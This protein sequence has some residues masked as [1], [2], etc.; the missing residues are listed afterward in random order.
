MKKLVVMM[1]LLLCNI[2]YAQC[3]TITSAEVRPLNSSYALGTKPQFNFFEVFSDKSAL[4]VTATTVFTS[5]TPAV[6]TVDSK[7]VVTTVSLGTTTISAVSGPVIGSTTLTVVTPTVVSIAVLPVGIT[8]PVGAMQQFVA[9]AIYSDGSKQDV[10]ATVVWSS[11]SPIVATVNATGVGTAVSLGTST[12]TATWSG[13][14]GP[15]TGAT[16]LTV[17]AHCAGVFDVNK[18]W[19]S[20][21]TSDC[22][23]VGVNS[24]LLKVYCES[25]N[26]RKCTCVDDKCTPN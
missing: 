3:P 7:G 21:D 26:G 25:T 16:T 20:T 1:V 10:T 23:P 12:I 24:V 13:K 17:A 22:T 15:F 5:S 8:L 9:T 14:G 19:V 11:S 18:P 4:D 2:A 6:A